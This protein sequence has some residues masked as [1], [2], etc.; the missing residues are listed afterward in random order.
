MPNKWREVAVSARRACYLPALQDA[1]LVET[2]SLSA[3]LWETVL[4]SRC[5]YIAQ[6]RA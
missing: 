3:R 6:H 2:V 1:S 4:L 5:L